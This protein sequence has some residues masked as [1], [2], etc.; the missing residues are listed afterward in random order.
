MIDEAARTVSTSDSQTDEAGIISSRREEVRQK[1][2]AKLYTAFLDFLERTY[3]LKGEQ[4]PREVYRSAHRWGAA[5]SEAITAGKSNELFFLDEY[6]NLA[7]CGDY[8]IDTQRTGIQCGNLESA[9]ESGQQLGQRLAEKI[10]R[11]KEKP[12][13]SEK[14]VVEAKSDAPKL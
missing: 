10:L 4:L 12:C 3:G 14:F 6:N 8:F 11:S 2:E 5:F 9:W 7:A 13:S 1:A